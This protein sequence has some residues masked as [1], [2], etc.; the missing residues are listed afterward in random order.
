MPTVLLIFGLRFYFYADEHEPIHIHV[1]NSDGRA[2]I[3]LV[4]EVCLVENRGIKPKEI[5][6]ALD[7]AIE[8]REESIQKWNEFHS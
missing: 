4:P 2:K 3:D 6:R 1:E 8:Y 5:R 7:L